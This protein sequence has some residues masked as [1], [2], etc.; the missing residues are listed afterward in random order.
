MAAQTQ[1]LLNAFNMNCV[2]HIIHGLWT[3][4]RDRSPE[5]NTL[6]S[7]HGAGELRGFHRYRNF[8]SF[9]TAASIGLPMRKDR[10]AKSP[11]AGAT[12]SLIGMPPG[13]SGIGRAEAV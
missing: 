6:T 7:H 1:I 5:Y 8:P 4:P 10:C 11:S 2:G 12:V 9:K 3:H 13:T